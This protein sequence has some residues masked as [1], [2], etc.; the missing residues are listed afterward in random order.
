MNSFKGYS[1]LNTK[2]FT[3]TTFLAETSL[4]RRRGDPELFSSVVRSRKSVSDSNRKKGFLERKEIML[5]E[6]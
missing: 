6:F 2:S 1:A 5:R 4:Y 3:T